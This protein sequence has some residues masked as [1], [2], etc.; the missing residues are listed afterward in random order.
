[1][2]TTGSF[3]SAIRRCTVRDTH[4]QDERDLRH[5]EQLG[6]RDQSFLRESFGSS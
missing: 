1:M 5:G 3:F 2:R 4:V 6:R